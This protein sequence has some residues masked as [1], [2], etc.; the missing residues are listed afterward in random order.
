MMVFAGASGF[1]D[2]DQK[3]EA[4]DLPQGCVGRVQ[5]HLPDAKQQAR[6]MN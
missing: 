2:P 3:P 1:I 5:H 4:I 6:R